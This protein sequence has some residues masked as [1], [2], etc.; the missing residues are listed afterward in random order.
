M[1]G[2]ELTS[3][4]RKN[5]P[6]PFMRFGCAAKLGRPCSTIAPRSREIAHI[7]RNPPHA[8]Q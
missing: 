1:L 2:V 3:C 7:N 8:L 4:Y 6:W 5:L